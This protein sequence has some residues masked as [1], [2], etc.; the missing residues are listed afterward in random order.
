M[1]LT[2]TTMLTWNHPHLC[3]SQQVA[4]L[5]QLLVLVVVAV[6]GRQGVVAAVQDR[7]HV[8]RSLC[9]QRP[10]SQPLPS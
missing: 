4:H 2:T 5:E 8:A 7:C 9:L 6:G 10:R 1:R 3:K